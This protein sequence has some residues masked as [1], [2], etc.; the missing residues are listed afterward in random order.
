MI[1]VSKLK[2]DLRLENE[3][4]EI[5]E[6][7]KLIKIELE[8]LKKVKIIECKTE[9]QWY[10][11][12][13]YLIEKNYQKNGKLI[14]EAPWISYK[15]ESQYF[16]VETGCWDDCVLYGTETMKLLDFI[17]FSKKELL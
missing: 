3:I 13:K 14:K 12:Y 5:K 4:K 7:E 9:R 17:K 11:L 2:E 15:G 10:T 8:K 1:L 6:F 16:F